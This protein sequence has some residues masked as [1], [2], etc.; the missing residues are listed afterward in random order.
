MILQ[1]PLDT[2]DRA[3]LVLER[4]SLLHHPLGALG[5]VPKAW[6]FGLVV[7]FGK[8][9]ARFIEVKDASSAARLTA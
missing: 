3:E 6:V 7:Q 8:A 4:I 9:G 1:L 2:V 5:V